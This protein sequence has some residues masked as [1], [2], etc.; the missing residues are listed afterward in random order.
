[1]SLTKIAGIIIATSNPKVFNVEKK[2]RVDYFYLTL[3]ESN[4]RIVLIYISSSSLGLYSESQSK[5]YFFDKRSG[6]TIK[7]RM[8]NP[9]RL[10]KQKVIVEGDMTLKQDGYYMS[11]VRSLKIM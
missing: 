9:A 10:L 6:K 4:G 5:V 3:K 7:H 11:Y 2:M 1:M 8:V